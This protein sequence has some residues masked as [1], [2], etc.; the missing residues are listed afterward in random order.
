MDNNQYFYRTAIFT[1]KDN[2]V[3]LANIENV[4]QITP[5]DDWMGLVVS[6]ADGA[7]T[8]QD[9]IGYTGAQYQRPPKNLVETI[10]S[11][12]S[13]LE[14]GH[15]VKLA[16]EPVELPYYLASPIEDLELE[17]ARKLIK[18]DGYTPH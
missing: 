10:H 2:Q 9:L 17:K 8:I 14:E 4:A 3:A 12:L 1:R 15:I 6:L 18:D 13:R 11:V 5:L 16:A 7:H